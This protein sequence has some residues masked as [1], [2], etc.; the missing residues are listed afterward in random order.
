MVD[1]ESR[2]LQEVGESSSVQSKIG[3]FGLEEWTQSIFC[4]IQKVPNS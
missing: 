4:A 3:V 1:D 2:A